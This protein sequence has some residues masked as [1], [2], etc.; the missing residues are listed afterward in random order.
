MA[1]KVC[2][3]SD[4]HG[5]LPKLPECDVVCICGDIL[6]LHIQRDFYKSLTWLA[7]PFQK[8]ALELPCKKVIMIWGNHD[9]VGER[10]LK[11]GVDD[12]SQE[13]Y[14]AIGMAATF[15]SH[16]LFNCDEEDKIIILCD[17]QYEYNG[18]KFYGTSWC[19][20]LRNWAFYQDSN[21]LKEKFDKILGNTDVLLTHCPPKFGSQG[22]VLE[23]NWNYRNDFGCQELQDV[24]VEKFKHKTCTTYILS[25]HIH[26]GLHNWEVNEGLTYRNVSLLNEDYELSYQPFIF[27]IPC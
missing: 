2:A 27:E 24:I 7:G 26:S 13:K 1:M 20:E 23:T 11:Y 22:V 16:F 3:I 4:I 19:P 12:P 9:F 15:Q 17:S 14:W 10:L 8:W 18:I 21:G 5:K 6:P 25:G